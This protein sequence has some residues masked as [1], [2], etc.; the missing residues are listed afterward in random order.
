MKPSVCSSRSRP[1]WASA[2]RTAAVV[3]E[4]RALRV[5]LVQ[6]HPG[7]LSQ[8]ARP[9]RMLAGD[10]H[11][12]LLDPPHGRRGRGREPTAGPS[13]RHHR[14]PRTAPDIRLERVPA[15]TAL[16]SP[17]K[18][19]SRDL[20]F[21]DSE[22][23]ACTHLRGIAWQGPRRFFPDPARTRRILSALLGNLTRVSSWALPPEGRQRGGAARG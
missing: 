10:R 21:A 16:N 3:K 5:N 1:R 22:R 8:R 12:L 14:S 19:L 2:S 20:A 4:H 7:R 11:A 18:W 15:V 23:S 6:P 9:F 13:P 17:P